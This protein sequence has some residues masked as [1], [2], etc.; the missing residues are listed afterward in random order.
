MR[1]NDRELIRIGEGRVDLEG[2][3]HHMKPQEKDW[4][5]W[6][7]QPS[8]KERTFKLVSNLLFYY[9]VNE[10]E[11]LGV[12][13][14]ENAQVAY[15]RP[16]KGI[17]FAFS[18][19][20]KVTD[21]SR[22]IERKHIFSCR[23]Q[24]DVNKWVSCLKVASYEHWRSQCIILKT[25]ISMRTG[26]DPILDYIRQ[27]PPVTDSLTGN[28]RRVC[29]KK[30]TFYSHIEADHLNGIAGKTDEAEVKTNGSLEVGKLIDI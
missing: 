19:V 10:Q 3:L 21:K 14:L 4:S 26:K 16:Y 24:D 25:K 2:I 13:V 17:P 20:F 15:E 6:Y 22:D 7:Q 27:K 30:S 18:L 29:A 5:D 12:I 9:R 1:F 11:P 28:D 23:C 8:F